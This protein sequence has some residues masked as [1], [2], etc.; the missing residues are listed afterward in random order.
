MKLLVCVALAIATSWTMFPATGRA[1]IIGTGPGFDTCQA[2]TFG[3][4]TAWRSSSPYRQAGIY[5]GGANRACADGPLTPAWV[6]ATQSQGW[7]L[8][9]IYVGLQ[10]PCVGQP[11][12]ALIDPGSAGVQGSQS[13]DDAVARA[14]GFGIPP[15]S[16]VY[17][18][19]EAYDRTQPGCTGAVLAFL[20]GWTRRLHAL[21]FLS[22]VY[23]SA[24]SLMTDLVAANHTGF[25]E[26]D[27]IWN[28]HWDGR[29]QVFGD[30]V[31]PDTLWADHQRIH[32]YVGGHDETYGGVTINI[33]NDFSDGLFAGSDS[34]RAV[35]LRSDGTTGYVLDGDGTLLPFGGA[36]AVGVTAH[37]PGWDIARGL[38]LR[39]DGTSGYV[40]D[41][42]GAV[43][44]FGGAP[45]VA[46]SGYWPGWDIV[47][48]IALR[49]DGVSGYVLD[50]WGAVHP[51]G[52]APH[53]A[54]AG[55]WPGWDIA[56]DLVLRSDGVS[57][58]TLDGWGSVHSIGG[59]PAVPVSTYWFG[60][61]I[62]RGLVLNSGTSSGYIVDGWG[63]VHSFGGAATA[64]ASSYT[65]GWDISRGIALVGHSGTVVDAV[66]AVHPFTA[67]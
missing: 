6:A 57:G 59:A 4:M 36:P 51:F 43:H 40:V 24:N 56:R 54:V 53:V 11:G 25:A 42:Y 41:G 12:M 61:D 33:D 15:A 62:A 16:P 66:G 27:G 52:G 34:R 31:L 21:G 23:G 35:A 67:P 45:A 28:G 13:A 10:A 37:W 64:S 39:A 49:A 60:W 7:M 22:A 8:L 1:A 9:P 38:A 17:F 18:D 2:P 19:M 5:I 50:A 46:T 47:R 48:G 55:Y 65:P 26:P 63:G 44:P 30:P 58:Y 32:Q 14:R 3:S 20:D 29:A